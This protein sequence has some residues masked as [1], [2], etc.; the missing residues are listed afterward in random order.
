MQHTEDTR[1]SAHQLS[2]Q[3][4]IIVADAEIS[5][6]LQSPIPPPYLNKF[7]IFISKTPRIRRT[8]HL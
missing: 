5:L 4:L 3:T 7:A 6:L 2:K 8:M 1:Q